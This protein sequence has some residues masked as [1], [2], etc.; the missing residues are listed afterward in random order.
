MKLLRIKD[1]SK[2]KKDA[3]VEV[4]NI[5]GKIANKTLEQLEREGIFVFPEILK[6]AEDI[7]K[8][9]MILQGVNDFYSSGNMMGFLG[10]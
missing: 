1:N 7:T 10:C 9:Q 5:T 2:I 6:D 4:E 8:D 3:F